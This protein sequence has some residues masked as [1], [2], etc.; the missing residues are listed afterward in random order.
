MPN[1]DGCCVISGA[2]IASG[3]VIDAIQNVDIT[4]T[5]ARLLGIP[6]PNA[7]GKVIEAALNG[8]K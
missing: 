1:M 4:P 7:D 5:M 2:G 3:K 8:S 6:F